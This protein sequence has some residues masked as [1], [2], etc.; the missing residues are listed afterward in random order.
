MAEKEVEERGKEP[1][2]REEKREKERME[3]EEKRERN[4]KER[5]EKRGKKDVLKEKDFPELASR[6][7]VVT[8]PDGSLWEVPLFNI[9]LDRAQRLDHLYEGDLNEAM[10]NE[11]SKD[12]Q[13]DALIIN[14][15]SDHMKWDDVK[16][17]SELVGEPT[18][19]YTNDW[20]N[21]DK[22]VYNK[23]KR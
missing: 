11:V 16:E 3:R 13:T 8:M 15:L 9:A 5:E 12:F 23:P 22:K 1:S 2:E 20:L 7:V 6:F 18:H 14:W 21:A 4:R 17:F 19:D 10:R